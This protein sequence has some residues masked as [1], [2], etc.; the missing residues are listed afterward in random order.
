MIKLPVK[1]PEQLRGEKY[2][3]V[4]LPYAE[5]VPGGRCRSAR[6]CARPRQRQR[7]P[8]PARDGAS[9]RPRDRATARPRD[10]ATARAA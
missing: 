3:F 6:A 8:A 10:R 5:F 1:L 9:A 4:T 2:A 7:A